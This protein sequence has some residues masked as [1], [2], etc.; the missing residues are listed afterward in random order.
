MLLEAKAVKTGCKVTGKREIDIVH[1]MLK[2]PSS[3]T[4][5]E[6]VARWVIRAAKSLMKLMF[7]LGGAVNSCNDGKNRTRKLTHS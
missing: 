3:I 6:R 7:A 1:L 4:F 5:G 2:S